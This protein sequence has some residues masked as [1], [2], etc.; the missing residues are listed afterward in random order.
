[1]D[2]AWTTLIPAFAID[3]PSMS[4]PAEKLRDET[5]ALPD[6]ARAELALA[7]IESLDRGPVDQDYEEAWSKEL[8]SRLKALDDGTMTRSPAEDVFD[9]A[10][11]R[12]ARG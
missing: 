12:L 9:R 7:L 6:D 2:D 11:S 10:R 3:S 1:M 8:A 4:K 5:L